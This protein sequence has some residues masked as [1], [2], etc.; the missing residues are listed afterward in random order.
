ML[1]VHLVTKF[2]NRF[3]KRLVTLYTSENSRS[4]P[5]IDDGENREAASAA[6]EA[7]DEGRNSADV[8][9]DQPAP[10][11]APPRIRAPIVFDADEQCSSR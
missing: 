5:L 8:G 7:E 10:S 4:Q 2:Y 1:L 6:E 9:G 3:L 11:D